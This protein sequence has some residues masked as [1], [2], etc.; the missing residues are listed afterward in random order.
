MPLFPAVPIFVDGLTDLQEKVAASNLVSEKTDASHAP[1]LSQVR[2]QGSA[3]WTRR[4]SGEG[5]A[6][7]DSLV[8]CPDG[9]FAIAGSTRGFGQAGSDLW[10]VRTSANGTVLWE[11]IVG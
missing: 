7:G 8:R 1:I 6:T 11:T 2:A 9:G 3:S 10:L 5:G 4:Y